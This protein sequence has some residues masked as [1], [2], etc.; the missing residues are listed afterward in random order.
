MIFSRRG[1]IRGL[2]ATGLLPAVRS[3]FPQMQTATEPMSAS[4]NFYIIFHGAFGFAVQDEDVRAGKKQEILAFTPEMHNRVFAAGMLRQEQ[5][6]APGQYS[7]K[8]DEVPASKREPWATVLNISKS[9]PQFKN[10]GELNLVGQ[11]RSFRLPAPRKAVSLRIF[12]VGNPFL[13]RFGISSGHADR[14]NHDVKQ[15]SYITA[16]VYDRPCNLVTINKVVGR[17]AEPAPSANPL[18]CSCLH[19]FGD[20]VF[21]VPPTHISDAF[22]QVVAAF[23]NLNISI[24]TDPDVLHP[25]SASHDLLPGMRPEDIHGLRGPDLGSFVTTTRCKKAQTQADPPTLCGIQHL[26]VTGMKL[27]RG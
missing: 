1:F 11:Y 15:L 19:I 20:S 3:A 22:A 26:L 2:A 16:F 25:T 13:K 21:S 10:I 4:E 14:L 23:T 18:T 27:P 17:P 12:N 9:D 5:T 6:V 24:R 8:V 7:I